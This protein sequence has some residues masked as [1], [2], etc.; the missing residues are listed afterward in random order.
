M[1]SRFKPLALSKSGL[2]FLRMQARRESFGIDRPDPMI[3]RQAE[4]PIL[5]LGCHP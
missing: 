1:Q 4:A 3:G 2:R 5:S